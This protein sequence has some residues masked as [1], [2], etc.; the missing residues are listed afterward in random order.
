MPFA[1]GETVGPY[2][3]VAQLGQG[4]M[5][6]V[7]QAYH[8]ALDRYVAIKVLHYAFMDDPNF[9]ARFQREARVVAKLEHPNI[10]PVY[11]FSEFEGRP[12]LVMKFI[13]GET[14][15]DRLEKGPL[16]SPE[17]LR[18]VDSV[19]AALAYAHRQ[20]ILHRDIKPSN[21]LLGQ[22]GQIYLADFGLAR[23]VETGESS[24]TP[25]RIVGTPQYISPEQALSKPNLDAR[26]DIYSFGVMLYELTVGKVPFNAESPFSI[27]HDHIY[28]PLPMP[29]QANPQLSK[30]LEQVLLKALAKNPDD[31]YP[32]VGSLVKAF[33]T[34]LQMDSA[35]PPPV[36]A[37]IN[38]LAVD[39]AMV[40]AAANSFPDD[41]PSSA[42]VARSESPAETPVEAS[43]ETTAKQ[44]R[45]KVKTIWLI[46]GIG[47]SLILLALCLVVGAQVLKNGAAAKATRQAATQ[48]VLQAAGA[49]TAAPATAAVQLGT[50]SPGALQMALNNAVASWSKG[51]L[52]DADKQLDAVLAFSGADVKILMADIR[53]LGGQQAWLP[54]ALLIGKA[55]QPGQISLANITPDQIDKIHEVFYNAAKD[56]LSG[57]L[58]KQ[59]GGHPLMVV[60]K[61]RYQ[62]YYGDPAQAQNQLNK[63]LTMPLQLKRFPEAR[64]LQVE[65]SIQNKTMQQANDQLRA[66]LADSTIP[67]WVNQ[68]ALTLKTQLKP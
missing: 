56:P 31:R 53:Y 5:A 64:L 27:I 63:L 32:D 49:A 60:A 23:L 67:V 24:L 35:N 55:S 10:V 33:H 6:T 16:S 11:D 34:A 51:N 25:D 39:G 44:A 28:T 15:K 18:V 30:P 59:A 48:E 43:A 13:E 37:N 1:V 68:E 7:Y 20:N 65:E 14:L 41:R 36:G 12:Y 8:P 29:R 38:T 50:P 54:A 42:I 4:G 58:F 3:L 57:Q 40:T 52:Q 26:S 62:L 22:D 45:K 9:L 21:V 66:L 17:I 2:T 47:G 19:G 61:M 46:L